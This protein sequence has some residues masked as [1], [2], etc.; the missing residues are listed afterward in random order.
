LERIAELEMALN[1]AQEKNSELRKE[2]DFIQNYNTELVEAKFKYR[3]LWMTERRYSKLLE[4]AGAE[5]SSYG[6]ARSS[7]SSSP[8]YRC[9]CLISC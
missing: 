8:Y 3:N 6:Q 5:A 7:E 4:E 1:T 2:I 9:M